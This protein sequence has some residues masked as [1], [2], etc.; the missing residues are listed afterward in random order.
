MGVIIEVDGIWHE[1]DLIVLLLQ[2]QRL[3]R[4]EL[5][6]KLRNVQQGMEKE[7]RVAWG[8][9][10]YSAY[11]YWIKSLKESMIIDENNRVLSL[12]GLGRWI[13]SSALGNIHQRDS[14]AQLICEKCSTCNDIVLCAPIVST[15]RVN[16]KGAPFMDMR[17]PKCGS[18]S[19]QNNLGGIASEHE[20]VRF[21]NQALDELAKFVKLEAR[22]I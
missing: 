3:G 13:A 7:G 15:A 17:C 19:G 14:F 22:K 8:P 20:F 6:A 9:H 10:S 5:K 21:Y 11:N 16:S 12:T 18:L 1:A 4:K 2:K